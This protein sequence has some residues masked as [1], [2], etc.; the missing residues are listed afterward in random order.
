[1]ITIFIIA[2][3]ICILC[4]ILPLYGFFGLPKNAKELSE[5]KADKNTT[6]NNTETLAK[7][8]TLVTTLDSLLMEKNLESLYSYNAGQLRELEGEMKTSGSPYEYFVNRVAG[9]YDKIKK[10]CETS[11]RTE[12]LSEENE[13]MKTTIEENKEKIKK[14]QDDK[15]KLQDQLRK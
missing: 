13:K 11:A 12:Q 10:Y 2:Y 6:K 3:V 5:L 15:E 1:M 4:A 9:L 14:L 7:F 8:K